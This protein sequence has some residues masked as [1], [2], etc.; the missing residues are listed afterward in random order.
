MLR[1]WHVAQWEL[2]PY[3]QLWHLW[4]HTLTYKWNLTHRITYAA[5]QT[6]QSWHL[7]NFVVPFVQK[8][9]VFRL[10]SKFKFIFKIKRM[11]LKYTA[12]QHINCQD[13]NMNNVHNFTI[14]N[15]RSCHK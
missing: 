14:T 13:S 10:M 7:Q 6:V 3:F 12:F 4:P 2:L 11:S 9:A 15:F 5:T 8:S 1:Q